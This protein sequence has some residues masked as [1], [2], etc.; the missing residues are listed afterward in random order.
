MT[1]PGGPC[2]HEPAVNYAS[3][4]I[5]GPAEPEAGGP[6]PPGADASRRERAPRAPQT[7]SLFPAPPVPL[8]LPVT[9]T[10]PYP[11]PYLAGRTSVSR[12]FRCAELPGAAYQELLDAGFRRS[13]Q[14]FYQPACPGC[15]AC[16][17]LRVPVGTFRAS[18]SQRRAWRRNRDLSVSFGRPHLTEERRDLYAR[19]MAERHDREEVGTW[20]D[21]EDF[22]YRSPTDTVEMLYRDRGGRLL[23]VGVCDA[24]PRCLS[25]VY[26]YFDPADSP[27]GLG[28]FSSL[29]EI[30]AAASMGLP[31][32]YLGF[33]VH[34]C[35]KMEYKAGFRPHEVLGTDGRWRPPSPPEQPA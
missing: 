25:S 26:F 15:R 29:V 12:G 17:A 8:G 32:Y 23:G 34:G 10:T 11:C 16:V 1:P 13:G 2:Y 31:Y 7:F 22:L 20:E 35:R 33:W 24:T 18:R 21:L 6:V 9:T 28:T 14:V 3:T 27:R 5:P 19:Y 30:R 4:P